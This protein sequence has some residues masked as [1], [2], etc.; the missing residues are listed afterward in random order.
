MKG[1]L[2]LRDSLVA[3]FG[4]KCRRC[5]Y[6]R[7]RRALHFHHTDA[8]EKKDWSNG[9]GGVSLQEVQ[10]HPE[11]FEM[12]CAN[13]HVERHEELDEA[14]R[15]YRICGYCEQRF[16]SAPQRAADGR[17]RY[18]SR[19][20]H[21][22]QREKDAEQGLAER[23][24]KHVHKTPSCWVWTGRNVIKGVGMIQ[25]KKPDGKYT[26]RSVRQVAYALTHGRPSPKPL[27][28]SCSE[29]RCVRHL[30]HPNSE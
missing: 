15:T 26:C 13:C 17:G 6:S 24:W 29:Q 25:V 9:R 7:C 1:N 12:L 10:A 5:G 21:H 22:K 11:R 8:S 4:G 18:C 27:G 28:V 23:F 3:T 19:R 2:R 30:I 20:C 14:K 16:R